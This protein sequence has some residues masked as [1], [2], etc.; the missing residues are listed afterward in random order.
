MSKL[1]DYL[2]QTRK[3]LGLTLRQAETLTH[4]SNAYIS[5]IESG[6]RL[7]PHP[8]ILRDL[9]KGYG[10]DFQ[11]LIKIAGYLD[12]N[13]SS[14][15]DDRAEV[16]RLYLKAI[17]DPE[18]SYGRRAKGRVDFRTKKLIADLYKKLKE[19]G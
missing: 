11:E 2:L 17:S 12:L 4:V 8:N 7:D 3:R 5:Q 16:E 15:A 18:F 9:A 6:L 1:G 14:E 10:I 13:S 19:E